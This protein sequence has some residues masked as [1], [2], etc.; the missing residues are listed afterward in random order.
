VEWVKVMVRPWYKIFYADKD[1]LDFV[2]FGDEEATRREVEFIVRVLG[3]AKGLRILDLCCG[4]GRHSIELAKLG[5]SVV[6]LDL[7]DLYL[8]LGRERAK[9]EGVNVKFVRQDMREPF[10]HGKFDA[11]ISMFTSFGFFEDE[12]NMQVLKNVAAALK[13]GG[14]FLLDVENKYYFIINNVLKEG[15]TWFDYDGKIVLIK[16]FYDVKEEREIMTVKIIKSGNVKES[17]YNI[18]LYGYPEILKMLHNV[19]L[20]PQKLFGDYDSSEFQLTSRRMI[21]LANKT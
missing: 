9:K 15:K 13:T 19:G 4:Y 16:N 12:D 5:Y 11:V 6:G 2:G 3:L 10:P 20:K 7:S 14:K 17:G 21:I 8:R 1:F 18:R